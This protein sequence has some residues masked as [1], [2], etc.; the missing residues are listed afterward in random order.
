MNMKLSQLSKKLNDTVMQLSVDSKCGKLQFFTGNSTEQVIN[1]LSKTCPC[2]KV[3]TLFFNTTYKELGKNFSNVLESNGFKPVNVIMPED[4][5]DN[6]EDYSKMFTLPEDVRAIIT[7]DFRLNQAIKYFA[8]VKGVEAIHVLKELS[9]AQF[10]SPKITIKN[11]LQLETI[12]LDCNQYVVIDKDICKI[13][14][15]KIYAYTVSKLVNLIDYKIYCK[16]HCKKHSKASYDLLSTSIDKALTCFNQPLSDREEYLVECMINS[17]IAS[18]LSKGEISSVSTEYSVNLLMQKFEGYDR[19]VFLKYVLNLYKKYFSCGF[20]H[21]LEIPDYNARAYNLSKLLNVDEKQLMQNLLLQI[22]TLNQS[23]EKQEQ[24]KKTLYPQ[25]EKMEKLVSQISSTYH[26]LGGGGKENK[27]LKS[28]IY[29][30]GDLWCTING[31]SLV[32]ESGILEYLE[33]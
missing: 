9:N 31:M 26:A 14:S 3:A 8:S 32:R 23:K 7:F 30:A 6:L 15:P 2:G 13:S 25:I 21:L 28:T 5:S 19:I 27:F 11:N 33:V 18:R 17:E 16:L 12:T 4:F 10:I 24:L 1:I 29:H 22:E 20:D